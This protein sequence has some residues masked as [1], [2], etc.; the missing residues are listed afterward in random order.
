MAIVGYGTPVN[1]GLLRRMYRANLPMQQAVM[2]AAYL[3]SQSKKLDE[4]VGGE[5]QVAIVRDN[6]AWT[7][8]PAYI[9]QSEVFIVQFLQLI[10]EL[11]LNCVD[12]SI[13]PDSVF[14]GKLKEFG[15]KVKQLRSDLITYAAAHTLNRT[16]RDPT[17][18]GD[19]YSKVFLGAMT[20]LMEDGTVRVKEETR[21]EI[22]KRRRF[23][24]AASLP[25]NRE[26]NERFNRL[27]QGRQMLYIDMNARVT[28]QGS[29]S[30]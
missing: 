25:E 20:T 8:D 21:E 11:F 3:V 26:A 9:K 22:E 30:T 4:G 5:T 13:P 10:D 28:N 7:D 29:G 2:L 14:P 24:E 19:S 15:A 18:R 17:Y 27:I 1:Y 23:L 16:F 12:S 6:G